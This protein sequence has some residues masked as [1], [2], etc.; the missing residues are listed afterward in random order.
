MISLASRRHC[1][2]QRAPRGPPRCSSSRCA[3][4]SCSVWMRH[5]STF[6]TKSAAR[7]AIGIDFKVPGMVQALVTTGP[8]I[9]SVPAKVDDAAARATPGVLD[10]IQLPYGVAVVANDIDV[11]RKARDKLVVSWT[12]GRRCLR[13]RQRLGARGLHAHRA[14][15]AQVSPACAHMSK[16]I[17]SKRLRLLSAQPPLVFEAR[18]EL[19]YHAPLEPQNAIVSVAADGQSA[20]AW[21][22]SQWPALEQAAIGTAIGIAPDKVKVN[23]QL[24]GGALGAAR[25]LVPSSMRLTSRS[26]SAGRSRSSG[27]A[28]RISAATLTARRSRSASSRR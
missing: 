7:R 26:A 6:P 23:L 27:C 21:V 10:V 4:S 8:R 3:T 5:A 25:S 19:V 15:R 1:G 16:A 28:R 24:V 9:G 20:E 11:A 13:L 14:R 2:C 12:S 18:S 22:G 17:R